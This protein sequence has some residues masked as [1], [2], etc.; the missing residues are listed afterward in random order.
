MFNQEYE[1]IVV[2]AGPAGSIAARILAENNIKTLVIE[3]KQE[4]GT[5]KRCAEG[6][7]SS[8]LKRVGLTPDPRWAIRAINGTILYTPSGRPLRI[9]LDNKAGY[10]LE[11]KIFEKHLAIDAIRKGARYMVKTLAKGVIKEKGK[12]CGIKAVHMG[13]ELDIRS[14][15]IIAADGVDSKIAKSAGLNTKNTPVDYHSGFQYE[16]AGLNLDES[17]MMHIYFGNE[18]APKGY[19][20][21]FPKEG[22]VANVGIGILAELSDRGDKAKDYLDRFIKHHP[23]IFK[24]ASAIEINAGGVPVS[25][26][27]DFFVMDG[28]MITGD[29]AQQVNP[30]H[31]GGMSLAMNAAKIAAEVGANAIKE[32]DVSRERLC[33]Y[34][35]IWGETDGVRMRRLMKLR[36]F[37]EKLEDKDF[38]RLTDIL[39]GEDIIKLTEARYEFLTKL[40][41]KKAPKMLPLAR[42]FLS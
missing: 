37:L 23:D 41:V 27:M 11:R 12:A 18:V 40:L 14:K 10:I 6:I 8:A 19:V 35:K 5:P 2:G 38:E 20:W 30:I 13:K 33:E 36:S 1:A 9:V 25:S 3:K 42:K 28:L 7:N 29:A 17:N 39:T 32:G 24:D 16:M 4:I 22:D 21:I 34:E 26:S 15:L 31:G